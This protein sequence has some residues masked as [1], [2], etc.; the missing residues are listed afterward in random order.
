M[1]EQWLNQYAAEAP[2]LVIFGVLLLA[3]F[4]LPM[5][6]DIPLM[7][8]GYLCGQTSGHPHLWVMIPGSMAAIL[9]ADTLIF[10]AGKRW[11]RSLH[12]HW[13]M[14]RLVGGR[15]LARARVLFKRHG[16]KFVFFARFLPGVRTPAFFTAGTF[17]MSLGRFLLWDGSAALLSVPWV[18]LLAY[19]FHREIEYAR[20][21]ISK[22]KAYGFVFLGLVLAVLVGYHLLVSRKLA[23]VKV[24]PDKD[25]KETD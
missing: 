23:K 1:I 11:G 2:Y 8:G 19:Y 18:V 4:G 20:D 13:L 22:G 10:L 24:D 16:A 12:R 21:A 5:P 14:K 15:N 17:K 7:I 3:G 25:T 6:E 9:G